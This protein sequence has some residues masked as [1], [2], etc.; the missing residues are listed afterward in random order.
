MKILQVQLH[1]AAMVR[2]TMQTS[3]KAENCEMEILPGIGLRV[4][5]IR[6]EPVI[7]QGKSVVTSTIIPFANIAYM[8]TIPEEGDEDAQPKE[9]SVA[10]K[11]TPKNKP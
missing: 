2:N 1:Q 3:L 4:R 9:K 7:V 8:Y 10:A 5:H 11:G 6:K